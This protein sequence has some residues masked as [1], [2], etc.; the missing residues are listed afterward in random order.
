MDP[1]W[2]LTAAHCRK[3]YVGARGSRGR[4]ENGIWVVGVALDLRMRLELGL[5]WKRVRM[6][7]G[8]DIGDW[9]WDWVKGEGLEGTGVKDVAGDVFGDEEGGMEKRLGWEWAH[10]LL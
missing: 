6:R 10:P 9:G 2:V 5:G 3:E 8:V 1:R 7:F 4:D